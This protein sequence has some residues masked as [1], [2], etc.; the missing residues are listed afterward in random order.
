VITVPPAAPQLTVIDA[1]PQTVLQIQG[2]P[3]VRYVVQNSADL[4]SWSPYA[5]NTLSG[6]AWNLTNSPG[7]SMKFWRAVWLPQ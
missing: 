4:L 7:T 3:G 2:Q 5:T 1:G 6:N